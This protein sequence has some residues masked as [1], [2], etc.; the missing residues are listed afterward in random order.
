LA[1]RLEGL[2]RQE[3]PHWEYEQLKPVLA[4]FLAPYWA[5]WGSKKLDEVLSEDNKKQ[6]NKQV[7]GYVWRQLNSPNTQAQLLTQAQ[8]L[9]QKELQADK[10]IKDLLNGSLMNFAYQNLHW[11]VQNLLEEGLTWLQNHK[12]S[13]A[14]EVYEK[15][16][17]ENKGAFLYK[18]AI[19]ETVQDLADKGIPDF[20]RKKSSQ[21]E[22]LLRTELERISQHPLGKLQPEIK[23]EVLRKRL[24]SLLQ[25]PQLQEIT[26]KISAILI[27]YSFLQKP[28]DTL[29]QAASWQEAEQVLASFEPELRLFSEHLQAQVQKSEVL[30]KPLLQGS[31]LLSALLLGQ[32]GS[33]KLSTLL[34]GE[35]KLWQESLQAA[36]AYFW[37]TA[38]F[39]D[40]QKQFT[41]MFFTAAKNKPLGEALDT[42]VLKEN[43][44]AL[45]HRLLR[46][47][48]I[49]ASFVASGKEI[50]SEVLQPLNDTLA[51]PTKL[52]ALEVLSAAAFEALEK[53]LMQLLEAIDLQHLVVSEIE[54]MHPEQV[55]K[56]FQSFAGRYFKELINY[57]FGFGMLFGVGSDALAMLLGIHKL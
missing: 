56:L 31:K 33:L 50:F 39:Q 24:S 55:E 53:N 18:K 17:Q 2:L 40:L 47:P 34:Q 5:D 23:E 49:E 8:A 14:D 37:R 15:A 52:F 35:E 51:G 25:N 28:L 20:F 32:I 54:A 42:E 26:E 10:A 16:F 3:A 9:L 36:L 4:G 29:L 48:E 19:K 21:L 22:H 57:G 45:L 43:L 46:H 30:Q 6:I 11:V 27:E 38:A 41:D 7:G 44:L 1:S 12:K 13:L